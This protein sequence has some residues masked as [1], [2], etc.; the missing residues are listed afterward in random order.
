MLQSALSAT[1]RHLKSLGLTLAAEKSCLVLFP[2]ERRR[3]ARLDLRLDGQRLRQVDH[4]RFLGIILD[5]RMVWKRATD[6]MIISSVAR[7]NVLRRL[8][9]AT[10]GNHPASMLKLHSALVTSR[11]LY[12]L[13]YMSP[14]STQYERVEITHRRGLRTALGVPQQASSDNVVEE[15]QSL[16]VR[17]QASHRLLVQLLRLGE[18]RAG[19]ALLR[20]LR[21]RTRS[22]FCAALRTLVALGVQHPRR[23]PVLDPPW[24]FAT[25]DCLL[26]VPGLR[27][28]RSTPSVEARHLV[29]AHLYNSYQGFLHLYTDGSASRDLQACSAAFVIPDCGTSWT[30]RLDRMVSTTF[31]ETVA[32]AVGL[33]RLHASSAQKVVVLSDCK[34]A[35]QRLQTG[36]PGE[37]FKKRILDMVKQL[38]GRGITV[39]FQW[40]PSHVGIEGNES[41]D[42]L[43]RQALH[44]PPSVVIPLD[45]SDYKDRLRRHFSPTRTA[46]HQPCETKGLDRAEATLL[47]RLRT[48]SARTPAWLHKIGIASSPLCAVCNVVG[49]A[50]HFFMD[51]VACQAQRAKFVGSLQRRNLTHSN[52]SD[53]VFPTGS[54]VERR[55][56]SRLVLAFVADIG[57]IA[58]W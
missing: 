25:L 54:K 32:I 5:S 22:H 57:C 11:L 43:A 29:L 2:G 33:Q 20:R 39:K 31:T 28:K 36:F 23:V 30:G 47:Y 4:V 38:Q 18:T 7:H 21:A 50:A 12:P 56:V 15:A 8:A 53:L 58:D 37:R 35:L 14:S 45:S 16:P 52:V 26:E 46:I 9:G 34:S 17:L 6:S 40:I 24:T 49:D 13:P 27:S 10:W 3:T 44:R 51:C 42:L 41:A 1:Q 19:R 48:G 55:S